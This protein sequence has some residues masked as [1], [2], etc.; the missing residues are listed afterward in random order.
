L[1]DLGDGYI[2]LIR[3]TPDNRLFI[4]TMN[5]LQNRSRF[6]L[7]DIHTGQSRILFEENDRGWLDFYDDLYLFKGTER[8]LMRSAQD[9]WTHLYLY[10]LDTG[11]RRQLTK[12]KWEV[13]KIDCVDETTETI[14]FTGTAKGADERHLFRIGTDGTGMQAMTTL[15]GNHA[16]DFS[17]DSACFIDTYSSYLQPPAIR[18]CRRDGETK[19]QLSPEDME[20]SE[21]LG[22]T[23]PEKLVIKGGGGKSL[24]ASMLKPPE[25]NPEKKYPVL[26]YVYGGPDSQVVL[27]YWRG[28][29]FLWEQMMARN[30][31]IIFKV[32]GRGTGGKGKDFSQ[33]VY[34]RLG[35][36]EL[37]DQLAGVAYLKSL[38]YVDPERIGIWGWSFGGYMTCSA[39]LNAPDV[40]KAG[41]AVAPVTDWRFYDTIYTE[42]YMLLPETNPEGY[43]ETSLL[44]KS[45]NLKARLLLVHGLSDDNVHF[46]NSAR[47]INA[48]ISA[49]KQFQLM[50]YPGRDHSISDTAAR[51]HLFTMITQFF[52]DH[53]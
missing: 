9:G 35:E 51:K 33:T 13:S 28:T 14:Y 38:P 52:L 34:R 41:V 24:F 26:I 4:Q 42:R 25:M 1:K 46:Q 18:V 37:E 43:K 11:S 19:T 20:L 17:S 27:N 12:G 7:T 29:I 32:D 40:F 31:Y 45:A 21:S 3:W 22:L 50:V 15:P 5:R 39:L 23:A 44:D 10:D 49:Q 48:L 2:P 8:L 47:L 16:I 36:M 53:L 6:V 30:G